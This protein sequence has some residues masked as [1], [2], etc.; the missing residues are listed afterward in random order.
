MA[1]QC[2][3][4]RTLIEEAAGVAAPGR[5]LRS[6]LDAC[7]P[8]G[9]F[10]REREALVGLL[11]GLE[12]VSA[13]DDFEFRLR[14]RM[15]ARRGP[16][17]TSLRRLR[18]A[19]GLTAF[20]VAAGLVAAAASLYFQPRPTA[21]GVAAVGRNAPDA[22]VHTTPAPDSPAHTAGE[23]TPPDLTAQATAQDRP[24]PRAASAAGAGAAEKRSG[25]RPRRSLR[26]DTFGVKVAAIIDGRGGGEGRAP[27][28]EAQAIR[29]R[30]SPETLRVVLRDGRGG[31]YVTPMRSVSFGAQAPVGGVRT[32][33]TADKDKEGVW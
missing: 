7:G 23:K 19:P 4:Y 9:E 15:A 20:A 14:A 6:H 8:C 24:R 3:A 25:E 18:L 32:A 5:A 33:R 10:R 2:E 11:G 1:D 17:R 21:D 22:P 16:E 13:P 29:L 31:S 30:T 27:G 26:D 12:R 28:P